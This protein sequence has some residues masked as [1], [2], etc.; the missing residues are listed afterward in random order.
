MNVG[1]DVGPR[2]FNSSLKPERRRFDN[3]RLA[4]VGGA[5]RIAFQG[6]CQRFNGRSVK[7]IRS[8]FHN[9]YV[10]LSFTMSRIC[11][12]SVSTYARFARSLY[13]FFPDFSIIEL[14]FPLIDGHR[15][16]TF[17]WTISLISPFV[18][19]SDKMYARSFTPEDLPFVKG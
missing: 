2:L 8:F 16:N 5:K 12:L 19:K 18:S 6:A 3:Q 10:H 15:S 1:S 14:L 9:R 4:N 11:T 7:S 17:D 13:T